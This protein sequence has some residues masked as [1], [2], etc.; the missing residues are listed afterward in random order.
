MSTRAPKNRDGTP[1]VRGDPDPAPFPG[2]RRLD[3][4]GPAVV[5]G[6]LPD[7]PAADPDNF[8]NDPRM[9][10]DL[11][12]TDTFVLLYKPD[13]H[14]QMLPIDVQ[15]CARSV[16]L[17]AWVPTRTGRAVLLL[18][19]IQSERQEAVDTLNLLSKDAEFGVTLHRAQRRISFR[20]PGV[21]ARGTVF[22]ERKFRRLWDALAVLPAN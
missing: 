5:L 11:S 21:Y 4:N 9:V 15:E 19:F 18:R 13:G 3:T 7:P 10:S 16:R 2:Y 20:G 14:E 17:D 12:S 6:P 8:D 1:K 22:N